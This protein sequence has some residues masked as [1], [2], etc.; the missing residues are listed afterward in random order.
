MLQQLNDLEATESVTLSD[1]FVTSLAYICEQAV[2]FSRCIK[3]ETRHNTPSR[4]I[5]L[6]AEL[7]RVMIEGILC[8]VARYNGASSSRWKYSIELQIQDFHTIAKLLLKLKMK[9]KKGNA[10]RRVTEE[11]KEEIKKVINKLENNI[12]DLTQTIEDMSNQ[13]FENYAVIL[14]AGNILNQYMEDNKLQVT[15]SRRF[16]HDFD[17]LLPD[18]Y[19][20]PKET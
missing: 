16:I 10:S 15:E 6:M 3:D 7:S 20:D 4:S 19:D 11:N 1:K 14:D 8:F 17:I 13:A 12:N 18:G 5:M 9:M 2:S